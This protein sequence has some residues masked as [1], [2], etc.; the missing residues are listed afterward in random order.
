M[1]LQELYK[2]RDMS[3]INSIVKLFPSEQG[4]D[5]RGIIKEGF[6]NGN[7]VWARDH[8]N[9]IFGEEEAAKMRNLLRETHLGGENPEPS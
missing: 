1:K 4:E 2:V 7:E 9:T 8:L 5:I 3:I 6:K